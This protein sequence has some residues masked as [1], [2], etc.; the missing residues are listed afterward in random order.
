MGKEVRNLGGFNSSMTIGGESAQDVV[1]IN[2]SNRWADD[3]G[4]AE[5]VGAG[6][7]A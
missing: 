2:L 4:A 6:S 1:Q 3:I 7:L 5:V